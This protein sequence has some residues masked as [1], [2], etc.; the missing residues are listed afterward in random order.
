MRQ[1][2]VTIAA[3]GALFFGGLGAC[4]YVEPA[5]RAG[6][7]AIVDQLLV[8][9]KISQEQAT[10]LRDALQGGSF[11]ELLLAILGLG[12]VP[13]VLGSLGAVRLWR[14]GVDSRKGTL[15]AKT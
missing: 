2:L 8:E 5:A 1:F 12:G 15:T 6:G 11:W 10:Q 14:G 3:L 13:S 7:E 9:G 4:N